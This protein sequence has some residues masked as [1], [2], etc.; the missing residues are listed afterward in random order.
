MKQMQ[1]REAK[2]KLSQVIDAAEQG[3]PVTITRHGTPVAMVI[4]FAKGEELY[5]KKPDKTLGQLLLEIPG[6]L[7]FDTLRDRSPIR[8]VEL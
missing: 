7:D 5:P 3:E 8:D 4:P 2:A 1:L 6:E